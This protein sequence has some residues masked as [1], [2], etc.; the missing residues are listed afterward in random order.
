MT[1]KHTPVNS[2]V[3]VIRTPEVNGFESPVVVFM[4]NI[5]LFP[6]ILGSMLEFEEM[7]IVTE[8][9]M[10]DGDG[11]EKTTFNFTTS[12][13]SSTLNLDSRIVTTVE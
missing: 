8:Q 7:M 6:I 9:S 10:A 2:L 13:Y 12:C 1:K 4:S 5:S 3:S 11:Q